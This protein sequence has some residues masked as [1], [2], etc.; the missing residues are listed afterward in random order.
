[1]AKWY[2]LRTDLRKELIKYYSTGQTLDEAA[3]AQYNLK[4]KPQVQH[5]PGEWE[6][7][8][9]GEI[10]YAMDSVCANDETQK[11]QFYV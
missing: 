1:M 10:K 6:D 7:A 4:F 2:G 5:T 9:L 8:N 3:L 11:Y